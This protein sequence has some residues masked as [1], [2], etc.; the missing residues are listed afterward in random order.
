MLRATRP[1]TADSREGKSMKSLRWALGL[2]VGTALL[3]C[4]GREAAPPTAAEQNPPPAPAPAPQAGES[5]Q[6]MDAVARYVATMVEQ[7][8]V[9]RYFHKDVLPKLK[10]CWPGGE[11]SGTIAVRVSY[12]RYESRWAAGD[13]GVHKSTLAKGQ[14][15]AAR[16]CLAESVRGTSF[17]A[18]DH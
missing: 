5:Q 18:N 1:T 10:G 13:T 6:Q 15:D 12:R 8:R 16:R 2:V 7:D 9:N 14:E 4:G 17:P 11:G 3:S